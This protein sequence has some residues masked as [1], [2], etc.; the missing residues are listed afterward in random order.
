[1]RTV[2]LPKK[3]LLV[4][5]LSLGL[6]GCS[7]SGGGG[8]D[9]GGTTGSTGGSGGTSSSTGG[10]VAGGTTGTGGTVSSGGSIGSGGA[11]GTGGASTGRGGAGTGGASS[12][13]GGRRT[14]TGGGSG[15]AQETGGSSTGPD[16]TGG[17]V[18]TGGRV[19]GTGGRGSG[20]N[21][22]STGGNTGRGG[23]ATGG[24]GGGN[25]GG[26][27]TGGTTGAGGDPV[28]SAGCGKTPSLK[29]GKALSIS[30]SGT[31]R[32]YNLSVPDNYDNSHPYRLIMS[33][34]WMNG[35]ANNVTDG[36]MAKPY[37]GLWDLAAGSTIFV[38]PQ[39]TGNM[40]S[41][42]GGVDVE[43]SRQLITLIESEFCIDTSRIFCEGFSMG[44]SMSYAMACA[45]GDVVRGIAVHSGG[46][47]SG[48]V[49]PHDKPVAYFMTHGTEDTMC[50]YEGFGLP[51]LADFAKV[52]GCTTT[53]D[54]LPVPTST[55]GACLD[56]AGCKAGYPVRACS[57]VGPHT[58]S[59]DGTS[60]WVPK[61]SWKFISQF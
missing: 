37:Y 4:G 60:G 52:N 32:S 5:I 1:M 9:N 16:A 12:G 39:G 18:G 25:T 21:S 11:Q 36:S 40:W 22:L 55:A 47:M 53:T 58:P 8:A 46:S 33:Y 10:T 61:E 38:A 57:F 2:N 51:I 19:T 23:G 31:S 27:T 44:G 17:R 13:T 20:G 24:M 34:H 28:Q 35:T 50:T 30:V 59:P 29:T 49:K 48:C 41:N 45:M 6:G 42:S 7:P 15:G 43:F 3:L 26:Q 54:S 56:F 14:G